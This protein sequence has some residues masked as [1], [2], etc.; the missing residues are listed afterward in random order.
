M[1]SDHTYAVMVRWTGNRGSGTSSYRGYD[2]DHEIAV[3]GKPV[4]AGSSDPAFRG[5]AARH[6]P[7]ELL[8]ASL[9]ACHMLWYLHLC[10]VAGVLVT[11]YEDR[12]EGELV[13]AA[14]GGGRFR[15]VVLRPKITLAPGSD[16]AKAG[17]IHEEAHVK[18]FIAAS[19]NFPVE[20][21]PEVVVAREA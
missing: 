15:R 17:E 8:V 14:D 21:E 5:D 16:A 4:L 18:C 1:G 20:H 9:S 10:T 3:A 11:D 7:E 6:N 19:V 2:R 13:V 12:A